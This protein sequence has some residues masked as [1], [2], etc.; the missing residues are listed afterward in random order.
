MAIVVGLGALIWNY[1]LKKTFNIR[2]NPTNTFIGQHNGQSYLI[3]NVRLSNNTADP[4]NGLTLTTN[5][6]L[7]T[8]TN[9]VSTTTAFSRL[10][11][12]GILFPTPINL[13]QNVILNTPLTI[14]PISTVDGNI[15]IDFNVPL[16]NNLG[17]TFSYLDKRIVKTIDTTTLERRNL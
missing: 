4:I 13:V 10:Q 9:G 6:I 5:N 1:L 14:S 3:I 12:G 7:L 17:L 8:V 2:I 15:V 16:V 11:G